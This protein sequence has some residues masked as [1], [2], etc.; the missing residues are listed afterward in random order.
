MK[1]P[2]TLIRVLGWIVLA[3]AVLFLGRAVLRY[4]A[5][6]AELMADPRIAAIVVACACACAVVT[7]LLAWVWSRM[8]C[9]L[10]ERP[11][12]LLILLVTYGRSQVAKYL[13]GN[14]A[15]FAA[16]HVRA[17]DGPGHRS[18]ALA[19]LG[20][21]AALLLV[22]SLLL[23]GIGRNVELPLLSQLPPSVQGLVD[24]L[25]V[26]G[27]AAILGGLAA[28]SWF[29][30]LPLLRHLAPMLQIRRI[31]EAM[32]CY[33]LFFCLLGGLAFAVHAAVAGQAESRLY[34]PILVAFTGAWLSG[35]VV[36]GA[37]GG[38]G[39]R[40]AVFTLL[41]GPVIGEPTALAVALL[42][43]VVTVGGDVLHA[44][45]AFAAGTWLARR[46]R[47]DAVAGANR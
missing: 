44:A 1:F 20:E 31:L 35:F 22:S 18:L 47:N 23:A 3:L 2:A 42:L 29:R 8:V 17:A 10:E 5:D 15:H 27:V 46:A 11:A 43:R 34:L 32:A 36:P 13:P 24:V 33:L 40:E 14:V 7:I 19:T 9:A 37:P 38:L 39:V 30:R 12:L 25:A 6:A 26:A 28:A 21:I 41:M 45:G 4:G 16:R